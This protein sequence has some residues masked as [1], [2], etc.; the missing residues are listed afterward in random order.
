VSSFIVAWLGAAL[1]AGPVTAATNLISRTNSVA[2]AKVSAA[3]EAIEKEF[4]KLEEADDE[5]RAE[6]D[7]WILDNAAFAA[8]GGG[9]PKA[10]LN[11]RIRRR[12][13]SVSKGYL[14]FIRRHPKH[15]KVRIAYAS[16]LSDLGDEDGEMEHLE[17]AR[18][19]DP[20]DP[21]VWNNLANYYGHN[22]PV[23]NAFAYYEKAIALDSKEPV[24][25][26]NYGTTV[27]LFRKDAREYFDITE[28]QVF[29]KAL[30]LYEHAVR[31]DPTNFTL[32]TDVALTYYGIKPTRTND[33][34]VAWTN[35]LQVARDEIEREGVYI[36][37]A[38]IKMS[39]GNFAEA[40][41]HLNAITNEM[42]TEVKNRLTRNLRE[43]ES[44]TNAPAPIE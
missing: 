36:H 4:K 10:E 7:E 15:V 27:F 30:N 12:L 42:Y 23:T 20:S 16:F 29:N 25:Y 18:G 13:D 2:A 39:A 24:Y 28:Q 9:I 8:E 35:A 5:A 6:I 32:L 19:L 41:T 21:A 34:L 40:R 17:I 43:R 44:G 31:L 33:A 3:D 26:Q 11:R 22:G 14:D 1:A 38:R 37:L